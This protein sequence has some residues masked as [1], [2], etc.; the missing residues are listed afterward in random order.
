MVNKNELDTDLVWRIII[1]KL[2]IANAI[3]GRAITL[4]WE[5]SKKKQRTDT[6]KDAKSITGDNST[7]VN[8]EKYNIAIAI[9]EIWM[10][11]WHHNYFVFGL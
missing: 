5:P 1:L 7:R 3:F 8:R 6:Q 2:P 10:I 9:L 4:E 11:G